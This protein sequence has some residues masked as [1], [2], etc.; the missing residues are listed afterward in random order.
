MIYTILKAL[1]MPPGGIALLLLAAFFLVH[2]V[3]GR[4]FLFVGIAVLTLISLP[5]VSIKLME[6]LETYPAIAVGQPPPADAEA[7]LILGAGRYEGAPEYGGD[8]VDQIGLT[9]LRYG[10]RL[11]RATGL[12]IYVS[13]GSPA[14]ESPPMGRLM[15]SALKDDYGIEVAGIEDQSLTTWENAAFSAP[16]LRAGGIDKVLLVTSAWHMPRALDA[17]GRFRVPVIAAPTGFVS[18]PG[19]TAPDRVSDFLPGMKAMTNSYYAI[20]EYLGRAWYQ[21]REARAEGEPQAPGAR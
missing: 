20:R 21:V 17:F 12:P 7:I 14:G 19:R 16:M 1:L 11:H 18:V 2:G 9:R 6:G 5:V 10:A 15:A 13:G 3:L 4:L 8:T